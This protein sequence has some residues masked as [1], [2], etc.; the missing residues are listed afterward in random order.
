M[1]TAIVARMRARM[2]NNERGSQVLELSMWLLLAATVAIGGLGLMSSLL[3]G[4]LQGSGV[5]VH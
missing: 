2:E 1:M 5:T 4:Y 3:Q